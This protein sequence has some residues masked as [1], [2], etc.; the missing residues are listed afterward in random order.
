MPALEEDLVIEAKWSIEIDY[1]AVE[2]EADG[3]V[4]DENDVLVLDE[5][6]YN[7]G[8][9]IAIVI[10]GVALGASDYSVIDNNIK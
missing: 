10:D 5:V 7:G 1:D 6:E 4:S 3:Y 9:F 2:V 8:D